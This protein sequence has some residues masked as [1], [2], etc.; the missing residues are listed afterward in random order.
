MASSSNRGQNYDEYEQQPP[1]QAK[2]GALRD[3]YDSAAAP[4]QPKAPTGRALAPS[5]YRND[6][7]GNV[8]RATSRLQAMRDAKRLQ[9][10]PMGT[11]TGEGY[12]DQYEDGGRGGRRSFNRGQAPGTDDSEYA[13]YG[14]GQRPAPRSEGGW[15]GSGRPS[16]DDGGRRPPPRAARGLPSRPQRGGGY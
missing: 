8:S 9:P 11:S 7:N 2:R 4:N 1:P 5:S 15:S 13:G 12:G 3:I 10:T 16:F 14:S 6:D